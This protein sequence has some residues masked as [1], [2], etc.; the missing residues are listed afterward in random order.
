MLSL[1]LLF[2]ISL[3]NFLYAGAQ[4]INDYVDLKKNYNNAKNL[5]YREKEIRCKLL[6]LEIKNIENRLRAGVSVKKMASL[7]YKLEKLHLQ[8]KLKCDF[9][10]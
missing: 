2:N 4:S 3:N 9:Y 7:N 5:S 10:I 1:Y 6:F 8:K